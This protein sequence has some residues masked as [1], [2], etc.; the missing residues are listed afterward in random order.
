MTTGALIFAFNNEHVDYEAMARWS[1]GNIERHSKENI[2]TTLIEL[3][4]QLTLCNVKLKE[5]V[6][7]R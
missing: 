5:G 6:A 1:A 2:R 3:A 7:G 4:G